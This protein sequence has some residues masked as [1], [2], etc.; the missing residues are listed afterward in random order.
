M[1]QLKEHLKNASL[2]ETQCRDVGWKTGV[3]FP[4]GAGSFYFCHHV[5]IGCGAHPAS[6]PIVTGD[7]SPGLKR[8]ECEA[9]HLHLVSRLK[10]LRTIPPF[11]NTSSWR[12]A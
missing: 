2:R 9:D 7:L 8:P 3:P 5:Q 11:P 12:G 4:A 1:A 10:M 6:Y